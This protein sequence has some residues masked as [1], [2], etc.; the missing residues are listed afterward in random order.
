M[1]KGKYRR[2]K[3]SDIINFYFH[4]SIL[5]QS[6]VA[7]IPAL[8]IL[9]DQQV[10]EE[11]QEAISSSSENINSGSTLYQALAIYSGL[12]P[13]EDVLLIKNGEYSGNLGAV[14]SQLSDTRMLEYKNSKKIQNS[15]T[16]PFILLILSLLIIFIL[17]QTVITSVYPS[18]IAQGIK[19]P[20][21]SLV[22]YKISDFLKNPWVTLFVILHLLFF[23]KIAMMIAQTTMIKES[24]EKIAWNFPFI[25]K[26]LRSKVYCDFFR[27]FT[28]L[29]GSGI[30]I[31]NAIMLAG[32]SCRHSIISDISVKIT[33]ELENG[34]NLCSAF[35][36]YFPKFVILFIETGE[37]S[38]K[39]L[40][41]L[42][43]L[44]TYYEQD[45][46]SRLNY[47]LTLLEPVITIVMGIFVAILAVVI[48]SPIYSAIMGAGL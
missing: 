25:K 12:F 27:S 36:Y 15:L 11:L 29:Y 2:A 18:F 28:L 34:K 47:A 9:A 48:I 46:N 33:K 7:I 5:I 23:I 45:I 19:L 3:K 24:L 21:Y 42:E 22:F 10:S 35:E 6:G 20:F 26:T 31:R 43:K 4:L 37:T 1:R 38:G 30:D 44:C 8:N 17:S 39:L 32:N 14:L 16:Y 13:P 41:S 40:Y